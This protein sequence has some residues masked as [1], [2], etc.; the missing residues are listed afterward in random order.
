M[1]DRRPIRALHAEGRPIRA[2]ARELGVSRNTVR[3]ALD[4]TRPDRYVRRSRLD[5]L[6][7]QVLEVLTAY[8]H[9]PATGVAWR[10]GYQGSMSTFTER[11]RLVRREVLHGGPRVPG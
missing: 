7:P 11:V 4:P 6:E 3:R 9:M 2:I 8:P 1:H 10:L 5:D